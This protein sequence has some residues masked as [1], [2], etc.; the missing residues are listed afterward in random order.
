MILPNV[1]TSINNQQQRSLRKE[2][3]GKI[4]EHGEKAS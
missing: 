1:L 2:K 4:D 3:K